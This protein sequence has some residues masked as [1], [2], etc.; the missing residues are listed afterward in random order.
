[1]SSLLPPFYQSLFL[2]LTGS[3]KWV[4]FSMGS[5]A[6]ASQN[7]KVWS[8]LY[9]SLRSVIFCLFSDCRYCT[10]LYMGMW[11]EKCR[12]H[13]KNAVQKRLC[14]NQKGLDD[15]LWVWSS[16]P[17]TGCIHR[18]CVCCVFLWCWVFRECDVKVMYSFLS[19]INAT[20][21]CQLVND[22]STLRLVLLGI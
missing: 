8:H 6:E 22:K 4:L 9:I 21:K 20:E 12:R 17:N 2:F 19:F 1:M 16:E 5:F 11:A 14:K 10:Q 18:L 3:L 7:R 15:F 13:S